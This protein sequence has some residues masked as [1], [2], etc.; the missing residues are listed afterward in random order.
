MDNSICGSNISIHHPGSAPGAVLGHRDNLTH[1][2]MTNVT[3]SD[4]S[5]TL[6]TPL[7]NTW[8]AILSPPAVSVSAHM[9]PLENTLAPATTC[10]RS[11]LVRAS[12]SASSAV[13]ASEGT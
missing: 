11:T 3:M 5:L 6:T 12:L 10:L 2:Q 1:H 9:T 4:L 7:L 8:V 13:R